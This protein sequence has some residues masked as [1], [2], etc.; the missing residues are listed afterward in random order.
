MASILAKSEQEYQD[1]TGEP[2]PKSPPPLVTPTFPEESIQRIVSA[3]FTRQQA[4]E[5]LQ[6]HNGDVQK[7]LASLFARSIRF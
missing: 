1:K 7:V 5:G 6:E 2:P 3:G 4:T